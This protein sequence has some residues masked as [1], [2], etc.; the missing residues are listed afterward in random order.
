MKKI[1]ILTILSSFAL[2]FTSCEEEAFEAGSNNFF[3]FENSLNGQEV[4]V[5][6]GDESTQ[7]ITVYSNRVSSSARTIDIAVDTELSTLPANSY[8]LASNT[9]TIPANSNVGT[10]SVTFSNITDAED[11]ASLVLSIPQTGSILAG[12]DLQLDIV[13]FCPDNSIALNI[14]TD[15]WPDET[16][17]ELY[18]LT[19]GQVLIASGGPFVNPDDDFATLTTEF[20][21]PAGNYGVIVYDA[22]GDGI[23]GGGFTITLDGV[24][25][26]SGIVGASADPGNISSSGSTTFVLD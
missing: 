19:T 8:V 2:F 3:S 23:S 25:I 11:G 1:F 12:E 5:A 17:W 9:V 7:E 6:A 14:T 20:C 21:L 24:T 10:T 16:S 15:D 22:Y 26:A 4:L 13:L 18:D